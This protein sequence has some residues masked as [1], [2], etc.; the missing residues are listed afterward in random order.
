MFEDQVNTNVVLGLHNGYNKPYVILPEHGNCQAEIMEYFENIDANVLSMSQNGDFYSFLVDD[1]DK[2][3]ILSF[4]YNSRMGYDNPA[5]IIKKFDSPVRFSFTDNIFFKKITFNSNYHLYLKDHLYLLSI[6][7][8]VYS[9]QIGSSTF[10]LVEN[11]G[12]VQ[13]IFPGYLCDLFVY[14]NNS[15]YEY[16]VDKTSLKLLIASVINCDIN[17]SN[18]EGYKMPFIRYIDGVYLFGAVDVRDGSIEIIHESEKEISN[19]TFCCDFVGLQKRFN[20]LYICDGSV[21][22]LSDG[23]EHIQQEFPENILYFKFSSIPGKKCC[24]DVNGYIYYLDNERTLILKDKTNQ[25]I[26]A[27]INCISKTKSARSF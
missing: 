14:S 2:Q 21:F 13:D 3:E 15:L 23:V 9:Y 24:I 6:Y 10:D 1:G 12:K 4:E 11:L 8:N 5:E 20:F 7:G 17:I 18:I 16:N 26:I 27:R 25:P 22:L 19:I